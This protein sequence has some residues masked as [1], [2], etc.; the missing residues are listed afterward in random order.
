ML[1]VGIVVP[2]VDPD[3]WPVAMLFVARARRAGGAWG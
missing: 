2:W 3:R 1:T